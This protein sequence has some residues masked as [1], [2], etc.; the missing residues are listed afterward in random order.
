[1]S[2]TALVTGS[3]SGIG[4]ALAI[5]LA[6]ENYD[7]ILVAR[8]QEK[9]QKQAVALGELYGVDVH[10]IRADLEKQGAAKY[11]FDIVQKLKKRVD[12]L[13]NNAGFNEFGS[14][15]QT[16]IENEN[17]MISLHISFVTELMKYFIPQMISNKL[18]YI[19]N[20]GSTGSYMY[21]PNDAV[22][23]ATKAYILSVSKAINGELKGTG[24]SITTLCPGSTQT[25][26]ASKAGMEDT[27]LFKM[28]VMKPEKVAAIG[29]HAMKKRKV[30][31]VAG[32]YNKVLVFFAKLL[33]GFI[34]TPLTKYMLTKR[35]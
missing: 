3:T 7:L 33:S 17:K 35:G 32:G 21:C 34:L 27:L 25:E 19:L 5:K 11:V 8:N 6:Q 10:I 20:L 15:L 14:F 1:M 26:F 2:G 13:V 30:S 12:V 9:L 29:Y 24:V 22:Y 4:K 23:A 18:G 16:N 31:I 28:F